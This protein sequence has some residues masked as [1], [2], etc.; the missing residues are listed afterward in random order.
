[1]IFEMCPFLETY[2]DS[3]TAYYCKKT[4]EKCDFPC[5]FKDEVFADMLAEI[6]DT[7]RRMEKQ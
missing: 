6:L 2:T 5:K 7:L 4:G 3:F 1:M